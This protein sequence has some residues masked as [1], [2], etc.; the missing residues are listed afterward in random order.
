MFTSKA[1]SRCRW[2]IMNVKRCELLVNSREISIF[3]PD[4]WYFVR[5]TRGLQ[6][7]DGNR[8]SCWTTLPLS[9]IYRTRQRDNDAQIYLKIIPNATRSWMHCHG[10][11]GHAVASEVDLKQKIFD[12]E[13]FLPFRWLIETSHSARKCLRA[14]DGGTDVEYQIKRWFRGNFNCS[15]EGFCLFM[16]AR[17]VEYLEVKS[18]RLVTEASVRCKLG[19]LVDLRFNFGSDVDDI[20]FP[21]GSKRQM[22][23]RRPLITSKKVRAWILRAPNYLRCFK[24]LHDPFVAVARELLTP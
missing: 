5:R 3:L 11:L 13:F 20:G 16:W 6:G 15:L 23:W 21:G 18:P 1:P 10:S 12:G 19:C 2:I 7:S 17:D 14:G 24:M 4:S 8:V 22:S 9:H